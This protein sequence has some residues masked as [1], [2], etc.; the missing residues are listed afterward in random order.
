MATGRNACVPPPLDVCFLRLGLFGA[1]W[2]GGYGCAA[3]GT[4]VCLRGRLGIEE[5]DVVAVRIR[6]AVIGVLLDVF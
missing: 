4:G 2:T 3:R 6:V 5:G 1:R